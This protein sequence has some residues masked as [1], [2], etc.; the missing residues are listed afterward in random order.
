MKKTIICLCFVLAGVFI[1]SSHGWSFRCGVGLISTGDTKVK[2]SYTCGNP[3][4][5]EQK[6]LDW[7]RTTGICVN[8]GETWYYNCGDNDFM[9]VLVFDESGTLISESDAGRGFGSSDCR[10]NL[11][12]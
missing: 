10:G 11:S 1:F 6:C 5:K 9:Y 2:T 7:N 12:R 4:S 8:K 3:T